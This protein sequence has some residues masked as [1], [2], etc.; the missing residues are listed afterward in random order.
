MVFSRLVAL[1]QSGEVADE[2][3]RKAAVYP[4]APSPPSPPVATWLLVTH[5]RIPFYRTPL[6]SRPCLQISHFAARMWLLHLL[7]VGTIRELARVQVD[8]AAM[9]PTGRSNRPLDFRT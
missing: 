1:Q 3:H 4:P 5:S 7:R 9:P 8:E 2:L 6:P